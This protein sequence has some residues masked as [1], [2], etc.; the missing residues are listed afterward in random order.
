MK[1]TNL[2]NVT[3]FDC[4]KCALSSDS[5]SLYFSKITSEKCFQLL[6]NAFPHI[7]V[8]FLPPGSSW[9]PTLV[10]GSLPSRF[11][12]FT[13]ISQN[14]NVVLFFISILLPKWYNVNVVLWFIFFT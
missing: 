7:I 4:N 1:Y 14:K 3:Y 13:R 5:V 11:P 6:T 2:F 8:T 9:M 12:V 10:T